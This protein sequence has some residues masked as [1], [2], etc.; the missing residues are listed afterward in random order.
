MAR[1]LDPERCL[2]RSLPRAGCGNSSSAAFDHQ[3]VMTSSSD[4]IE[5]LKLIKL[6]SCSINE[7]DDPSYPYK[8]EANF[9]PP[10]LMQ[11]AFVMLHGGSEVM[12]VRAMTR[13]AIDQFIDVNGLR[14]HPRLRRLIITGPEGAREEIKR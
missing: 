14:C 12:I 3:A 11:V 4:I 2:E 1:R 8:L 9:S 10:E 6:N 7:S 13:E 5:G